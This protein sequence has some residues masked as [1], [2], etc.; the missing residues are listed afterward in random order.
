MEFRIKLDIPDLPQTGDILVV[1]EEDVAQ[2]IDADGFQRLAAPPNHFE[3]RTTDG[4]KWVIARRYAE[5]GGSHHW[6]AVRR[7]DFNVTSSSGN[8]LLGG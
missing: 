1:P 8:A 7:L 6:F 3:V 4:A 5:V 2:T